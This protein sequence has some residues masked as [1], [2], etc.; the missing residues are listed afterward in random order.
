MILLVGSGITT[1]IK[2]VEQL[3]KKIE[4]SKKG[5]RFEEEEKRP[6]FE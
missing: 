3:K 1:L 5:V 6:V 4:K 2:G